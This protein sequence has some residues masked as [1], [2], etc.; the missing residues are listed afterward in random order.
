MML[1]LRGLGRRTAHLWRS[2][3]QAVRWA[4]V[5]LLLAAGICIYLGLLG[6]RKDWWEDRPFTTNVI[7]G[8]GGASFGLVIAILVIQRLL[9]RQA[10]ANKRRDVHRLLTGATAQLDSSIAEITAPT[11]IG[12]LGSKVTTLERQYRGAIAPI[13]ARYAEASLRQTMPSSD[14]TFKALAATAGQQ[15]AAIASELRALV[16]SRATVEPS[17]AS[18]LA[19]WTFLDTHVK[20]RVLEAGYT[21][22]PPRVTAEMNALMD[23][24]HVATR[25]S[26]PAERLEE[27]ASALGAAGQSSSPLAVINAVGEL[28]LLFHRGNMIQ[29]LDGLGEAARDTCM[30]LSSAHG[31]LEY[32]ARQLQPGD[33]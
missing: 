21:W 14:A 2:T 25:I 13:E 19:E 7:S 1:S 12:E 18:A 29:A 26:E 11:P 27:L 28:A 32:V 3:D 24:P 22:M 16:P 9:E 31:E 33:Y 15:V 30:I 20:P 10:D 8:F 6:D 23:K 5:G 4:C 17:W